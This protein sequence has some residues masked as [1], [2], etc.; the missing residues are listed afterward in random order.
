MFQF[1]GRSDY[2][3]SPCADAARLARA[4]GPG[5]SRLPDHDAPTTNTNDTGT[6]TGRQTEG[7]GTRLYSGGLATRL[8]CCIDVYR[9]QPRANAGEGRRTGERVSR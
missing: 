3:H 7:I 1:S 8:S 2:S 5:C 9:Q 6:M 4:A